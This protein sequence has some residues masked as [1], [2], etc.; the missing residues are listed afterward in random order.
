[1][2]EYERAPVDWTTNP[3]LIKFL[4]LYRRRGAP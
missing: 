1:V 2:K 3:T 4:T